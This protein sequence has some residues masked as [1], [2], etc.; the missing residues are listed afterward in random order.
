MKRIALILVVAIAALASNGI[1]PR[2]TPADYPTHATS[3]GVTIAAAVIP[4]AQ[5][6][7]IFSADLNSGGYIV[8]EVAVYPESAPDV[9]VSSGDFM[10]SP[11]G[12]TSAVPP[13]SARTI[14]GVFD[15][16]NSSPRGRD[17]NVD[18]AIGYETGNDPVTGQRR[19]GTYTG[20]AVQNGPPGT[21]APPP[22]GPD[23]WTIKQELEERSLPEGKSTQ[24]VAGYLY[25]PKLSKKSRNAGYDLT[26]YGVNSKIRLTVPV[27]K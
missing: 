3:D 4:P 13:V 7:K 21:L 11:A 22:S 2:G 14:A 9:D 20:V 1:R 25:F 19:S 24:P 27:E 26:Y 15:R 12:E 10:L 16:K 17:T 18:V 23:P 8:I 5:V 6:R